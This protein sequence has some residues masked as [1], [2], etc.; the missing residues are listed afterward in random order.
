MTAVATQKPFRC[1]IFTTWE[2]ADKAVDLLLDAGFKPEQINVMC[3]DETTERHFRQFEHEDP[4][5]SHTGEAVVAGGTIGAAL[6][7]LTTVG[8]ATAIGIPVLVAGPALILGLATAGGLIGAMTTRGLEHEIADFYDQAVTQ[9]N[10]L[11]AVESQA[12][13]AEEEL[14]IAEKIFEEAG[15]EPIPLPEG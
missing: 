3:S 5:G 6:G 11:V 2:D 4:A 12:D 14:A 7:G 13:E 1:G 15:S 10:I 9:G 8:I